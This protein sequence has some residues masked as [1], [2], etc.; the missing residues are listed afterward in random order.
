MNEGR[1]ARNEAEANICEEKKDILLG[2]TR[3]VKLF[4]ALK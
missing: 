2:N 3:T 1:V 4:T